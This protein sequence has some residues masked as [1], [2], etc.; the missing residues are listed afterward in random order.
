MAY[1]SFVAAEDFGVLPYSIPNIDQADSGFEEFVVQE[2]EK[3]LRRLLGNLLFEAFKA[4]LD[5]DQDPDDDQTPEDESSDNVEE[6]WIDLRDGVNYT[7]QDKTYI[8][9]GELNA[10]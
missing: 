1:T 5:E 7:Y 4:G 8:I 6:R 9:L 2:Q 3:I 10:A